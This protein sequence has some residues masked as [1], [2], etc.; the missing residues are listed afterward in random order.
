MSKHKNQ[1]TAADQP[2]TEAIN[3]PENELLAPEAIDNTATAEIEAEQ[4]APAPVE[5]TLEE[6]LADYK[7]RYLRLTAEFDNFRKRTRKERED[8]IKTA[9]ESVI[10]N[11]LPVVD[12][13]ER[14]IKSMEDASDIQALKDGIVLIV[15][16]FNEFLRRQGVVEIEAVGQPLNTDLHEAITQIPAPTKALKGKVVDVIQKGYRLNEKVI[17]YSKVVVGE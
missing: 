11:V 16:K 4:P 10:V 1:N 17:R 13:F 2:K 5:P 3:T 6:Q 15:S 14:A 9:G 12:D 7:D 8:L